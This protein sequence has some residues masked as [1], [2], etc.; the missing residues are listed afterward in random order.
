MITEEHIH[1]AL[2][3][4]PE[5]LLTPVDALRRKKRLS[6]KPVAALAACFALVVGLWFLFPG[7]ANSMDNP[8]AAPEN[9]SGDGF[10]GA[11]TDQNTQ[12]ST[13]STPLIATVLETKEDRIV[14]LP[15]ETLTDIAQTVTVLLDGLE[16][17]PPL[18]KGQSVK[19]YCKDLSDLT[20]PLIPY[21]I[22]ITENE[23][24]D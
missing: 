16:E 23:Q 17:I 13:G 14:V 11:I 24:E 22:E 10:L 8:G 3:L 6:W 7:A 2:S 18:E 12:H 9:G 1:D 5:E 19:L 15:G 20:K 4:L 21:R